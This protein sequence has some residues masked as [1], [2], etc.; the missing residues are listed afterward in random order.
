MEKIKTH[1]QLLLFPET[2][3]INKGM[4][5]I[6]VWWGKKYFFPSKRKAFR[7]VAIT[8]QFYTQVMYEARMIYIEAW[9]KYQRSVPYFDHDKSSMGFQNHDMKRKCRAAM[10]SVEDSFDLM[11][12]RDHWDNG[13]WIV[14]NH[15]NA[16]LDSFRQSVD[17]LREL[18]RSKNTSM[19]LFELDSIGRR[20]QALELSLKNFGDIEARS[21]QKDSLHSGK[22]SSAE[23]IHRSK[24]TA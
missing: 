11:N 22:L 17:I 10:R 24:L 5:G 16:V 15:L 9:I 12:E 4:Y 6:H 1:S 3:G 18:Y 20:T 8:N 21:L 13:N 14:R 7:F 19:E 2:S 23:L